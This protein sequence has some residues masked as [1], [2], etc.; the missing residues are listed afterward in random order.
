MIIYN[1]LCIILDTIHKQ[2]YYYNV[3][4]ATRYKNRLMD[5]IKNPEIDS[6]IFGQLIFAKVKKIVKKDS[7]LNIRFWE[8]SYSYEK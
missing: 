7:L 2:L 8:I 6:L 1:V 3:I 4:L 5:R